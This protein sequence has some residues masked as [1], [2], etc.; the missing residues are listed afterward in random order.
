MAMQ[1]ATILD[2]GELT[3]TSQLFLTSAITCDLLDLR[4]RDV[5]PLGN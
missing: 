2:R 3:D 5:E 4:R 1:H